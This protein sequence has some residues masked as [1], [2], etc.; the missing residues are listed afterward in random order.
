MTLI[1]YHFDDCKIGKKGRW[2]FV[3]IAKKGGGLDGK[4]GM[5]ISFSPTFLHV[6]RYFIILVNKDKNTC[7][8]R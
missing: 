1:I 2:K 5:E 6:N 7:N 8:V 3:P 4:G